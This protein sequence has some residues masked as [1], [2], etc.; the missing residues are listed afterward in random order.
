MRGTSEVYLC[1]VWHFI[2]EAEK[3]TILGK[4]LHQDSSYA[5][6]A[7]QLI[8]CSEL[9]QRVPNLNVV[10]RSK[11]PSALDRLMDDMTTN[12]QLQA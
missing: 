12:Q 4:Q 1:H 6:T 7:E 2:Q 3:K 9:I 8:R 10:A 5:S 11:V